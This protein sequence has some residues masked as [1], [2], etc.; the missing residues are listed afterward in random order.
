MFKLLPSL[1]A[2]LVTI[3]SVKSSPLATAPTFPSGAGNLAVLSAGQQVGCLTPAWKMAIDATLCGTFD[4]KALPGAQSY[5]NI[6][7]VEG[8]CGFRYQY[9]SSILAENAQYIIGCG[10]TAGDINAELEASL[11]F[12]I[13][14]L[15]RNPLIFNI[16]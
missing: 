12:S 8:A 15:L 11:T 13:I 4:A 3:G 1:F 9:N 14:S 7:S 6:K 5:Y 2:I 10:P 16:T